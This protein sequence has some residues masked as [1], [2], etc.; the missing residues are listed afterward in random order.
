MDQAWE[1]YNDQVKNC[2]TQGK[3]VPNGKPF[4]AVV[5]PNLVDQ[6]FN[7]I[8]SVTKRLSV[9]LYYGDQRKHSATSSYFISDKLTPSH[10]LFDGKPKNGRAIILTSYQ[11]L[12]ARHGPAAVK[13]WCETEKMPFDAGHPQMPA[14]FPYRLTGCFGTTV[15]DEAHSLRNP[16][17]NLSLTAHWLESDFNLLISGTLFY[18]GISDMKGYAPLLFKTASWSMESIHGHGLDGAAGLFSIAVGHPLEPMLC[19]ADALNFALDKENTPEQSGALIRRILS[20]LLVRRTLSSQIPFQS[21][22]SIGNNIP[23]SQTKVLRLELEEHEQDP[24][25]AFHMKNKRHLFIRDSNHPNR[26]IWNYMKL[27]RLVLASSWLGFIFLEG[28]LHSNNITGALKLLCRNKLI[29]M[30]KSTIKD[31]TPIDKE[32]AQ[33]FYRT[34]IDHTDSRYTENLELLLRGSPKLRKMLPILMDQVL[35]HGEKSCIWVMFPAEQVY[36][37]AAL[38]EVG[39]DFGVLHG[40][41]DPADRAEMITAFTTRATDCMVLL[42]SY[43]VDSSGLNLQAFCRNVHLFSPPTS[44]SVIEQAIGRVQRIGQ[45]RVVLVYEYRVSGTFNA[46][47]VNRNKSRAIPGIVTELSPD[48]ALSVGQEQQT[49]L[50]MD[51][52]VLRA[53][54]LT[55]L[56]SAGD[57]QPGDVTQHEK[58]MDALLTSLEGLTEY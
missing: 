56:G 49:S 23:P 17:S 11:T 5:P 42:C 9:Y 4:L 38:H 13:A 33:D 16:E 34:T 26:F 45:T 50:D 25:D 8:R 28:S 30:W 35:V 37:A 20:L 29:N 22:N 10:F 39:I 3:P 54:V 55:H 52:W 41:L 58:I 36:L 47:M 2:K 46:Y 27:R 57:Q 51:R 12:A 44:R 53:G 18:S 19:T 14:N 24:Y 43:S 1:E 40:G 15:F 31:Q 6:W 7:E 32:A 21:G 48:M